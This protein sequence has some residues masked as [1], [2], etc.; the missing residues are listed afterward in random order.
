[1]PLAHRGLEP[2]AEFWAALILRLLVNEQASMDAA[3]A[4]YTALTETA[5]ATAEDALAEHGFGVEVED[6]EGLVVYSDGAQ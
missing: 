6:T 4:Y 5:H 3:I 2:D 1:M